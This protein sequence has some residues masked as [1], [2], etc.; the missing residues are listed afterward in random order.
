MTTLLKERRRLLSQG[1]PAPYQARKWYPSAKPR[2]PRPQVLKLYSG[3]RT[4]KAL[5]R[6]KKANGESEE[7]MEHGDLRDATALVKEAREA[8]KASTA[9]A[10]WVQRDRAAQRDQPGMER[11]FKLT[12]VACSAALLMQWLSKRSSVGPRDQPEGTQP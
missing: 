6:A 4:I 8:L 11:L 1:R 7:K 5:S 3:A 9:L 12:A 10:S 2:S